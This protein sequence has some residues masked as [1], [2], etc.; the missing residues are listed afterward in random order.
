M[1]EIGS[2][3]VF[4]KRVIALN[5]VFVNSIVLKYHVTIRA[6]NVLRVRWDAPSSVSGRLSLHYLVL[7]LIEVATIPLMSQKRFSSIS[8]C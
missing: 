3:E 1:D 8:E 5:S 4:P 6:H 2:C 7:L